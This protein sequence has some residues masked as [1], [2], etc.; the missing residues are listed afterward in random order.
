LVEKRKH[1]P[2]ES[3]PDWTRSKE[4][5]AIIGARKS[6]CRRRFAALL[7]K[8]HFRQGEVPIMRRIATLAETR[9][10]SCMSEKGGN[11]VCPACGYQDTESVPALYLRPGTIFNDQ[12]LIGKVLGHGGF[13]ITYIGWDLQLGIRLAIKEYLPGEFATR[14]P[15]TSRVTAYSGEARGYFEYGLE[16]F[17]EEARALARFN[18]HAGVVKVLNFFRDAGTQTA[19]IVMAYLDGVTLR[20]YLRSQGE[21]IPFQA[22]RDI[23]MPVM[24]TLR[25]VHSAGMLHRDLSPDNIFITRSGQIKLIDFGAARYAIGERS[26]TLSVMLKHGYAPLEQY[27]SKGRQGPA[28]DVYAL[29]ATFYRAVTG[30]TPAYSTDRSAHDDLRPPGELGVKIPQEQERGLMKALAIRYEDRFQDIASF[31]DILKSAPGVDSC[32]ACQEKQKAL[33]LAHR[34]LSRWRAAF[35]LFFMMTLMFG[36]GWLADSRGLHKDLAD[37]QSRNRTLIDEQDELQKKLNTSSGITSD[38]IRK[39]PERQVSIVAPLLRNE[40]KDGT[41]LSSYSTSFTASEIRYIT[42][43]GY[44]HNNWPGIKTL[45]GKLEV[46]YF[47]PGK[48]SPRYTFTQYINNV[49]DDSVSLTAHGY[50]YDDYSIYSDVGTYHIRFLWNGTEIADVPFVVT[51]F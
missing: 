13:G 5:K 48:S 11:L 37:L 47:W 17:K 42:Y 27:S 7:E 43:Y 12:Y 29:A 31:Q 4:G 9:C 26:K 35:T 49:S 1:R 19:Y 46:E 10:L 36:I 18:D 33:K 8:F 38:L 50:G 22:A 24:D 3:S 15:G 25:E 32:E 23:L 45:S 44:L 40:R 51:L 30:E 20:E 6:S 39:Y 34:Q 21:K 16:Q 41:T 2:G 28:T 14:E